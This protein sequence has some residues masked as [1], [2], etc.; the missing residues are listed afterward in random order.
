MALKPYKKDFGYSY[1]YGVSATLELLRQRPQDALTVHL[2]TKGT[3]NKGIDE[4]RSRATTQG[5]ELIE[6]SGSIDRL[7]N[8]ENTYAVGV[9]RKFETTLAAFQNHIVLVNP[10]DK[11]NLGTILRSMVAFGK[12][13]LAIIKPAVD[14]F[15]PKVVRAS[16]GAIFTIRF[17]YFSTFKDYRENY[18]RSYYPFITD[19]DT[20]LGDVSFAPPYS[21]VFGSESEGLNS[22]FRSIGTS[23]SIPQ[24]DKVDSLNLS[25]AVGLA[26]FEASKSN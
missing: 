17:S 19:A 16:M 10:Q 26:L 4:I 3:K 9:F 21:L 1:A 11:G 6:S 5:V 12:E 14:I 13:D 8:T 18:T 2:H 23:V 22:T 20:K 15:D 7:T 25:I 24:S